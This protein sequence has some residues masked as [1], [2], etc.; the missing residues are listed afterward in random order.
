[1]HSPATTANVPCAKLTTPV[2]RWM[3]TSPLAMSA[4]AHPTASPF[5][6]YVRNALM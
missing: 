5:S 3:A 1:M 2:T 4:I 6:R